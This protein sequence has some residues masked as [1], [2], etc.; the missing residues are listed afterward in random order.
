MKFQNYYKILC[1]E[2]SASQG[3]IKKAHRKLA[4][5]HH[6]DKNQDKAD[7]KEKFIKIQEAYEVL[8]DT[9]KRKK[10]D[11][12]INQQSNSYKKKY[13]QQSYYQWDSKNY[14][15]EFYKYDKG[16]GETESLFSA[17]FNYFFGRKKKRSNY[18]YL[19]SGN[20]I[21]G[22]ITI[23]LAEAFIGSNRILTVVDEKL[24][25]TIKPGINNDQQLKIKNKGDYSELGANR[26]DLF[27][28]IKI[29]P[30]PVYTRKQNHLY[31][32][33]FVNI[34]TV[35]LGGKVKLN[36]F[37]GEKIIK[38]TKGIAYDKVL[39]IKGAGMPVYDSPDKFGDLFI[40][41]KYKIP[42]DFSEEETLLLEKLRTLYK[43]RE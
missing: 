19:Y 22:K 40:K 1:I 10:Y 34:Y 37:H 9:N 11:D 16:F 7:A 15:D 12:L 3:E 35:L 14:G 29:K 43:A 30:H 23:D 26:G 13:T 21:K 17:F 6:P 36:T 2:K 28:R 39:R 25:V 18:S 4:L 33:I 41:V 38:I 5:K 27:V 20:D 42:T 24:R 31:R 8:R 32:D